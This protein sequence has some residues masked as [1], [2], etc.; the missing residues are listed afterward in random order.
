VKKPFSTEEGRVGCGKK[1]PAPD[2]VPLATVEPD[3]EPQIFHNVNDSKSSTNG[4][5]RL[6]NIPSFPI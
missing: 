1:I 3:F 5:V 4:H 2:E 6:F